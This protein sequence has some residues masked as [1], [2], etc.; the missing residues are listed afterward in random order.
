MPPAPAASTPPAGLPARQL[1]HQLLTLV[2]RRGQNFGDAVADLPKLNSLPERDRAFTRLLV[3]TTLRRLGQIDAVLGQHLQLKTTPAAVVDI[4]RLTAAQLWWLETPPHAAVDMA[5]RLAVYTNQP[6]LKGLVN[7]VARK[8]SAA[9]VPADSAIKLL[10]DW[11]LQSWTAAYGADAVSAIARQQILEP[12]LDITVKKDAAAWAQKLNA[13]LLP[14]GSLRLTDAGKVEDLPGYGE[15]AWWVQDAAAALPAKLLGEVRGKTVVDIGAAPGG[16]TAQLAAAGANVIAVER[17]P[18]RAETL[19][20][21][22][23]RLRLTAEIV[24]AD[25]LTWQPDRKVDAVLLDAPCSATGTLRRH[26]EI[27]WLK[28]RLDIRKQATAQTALLNHVGSWLPAGATLVYAVCS[29]QPEEG[30]HQVAALLANQPRLQRVPV[31]ASAIGGLTACITPEGDLRTLPHQL[32]GGIDGFYAATLRAD[33]ST[34]TPGSE[35]IDHFIE[36]HKK[37]LRGLAEK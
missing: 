3:L 27:A 13:V 20:Q 10:P 5:V 4:L 16:K 6:H 29:L 1:A 12:P 21:N 26:P 22:L 17:N 24:V 28:D 19:K 35:R 18:A 37:T 8:L 11:L 23:Q 36:R 30:L 25:A 31:P 32:P 7:A 33:A 15:G 14:T 2:L 34:R 9:P